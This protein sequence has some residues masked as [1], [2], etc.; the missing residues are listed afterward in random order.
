MEKTVTINKSNLFKK[1]DNNNKK[2]LLK[3]ITNL[4]LKITKY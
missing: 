1:I 4:N 3:K 2:K